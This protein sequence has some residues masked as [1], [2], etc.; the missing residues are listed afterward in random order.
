[1]KYANLESA[2][3]GAAYDDLQKMLDERLLAIP[4]REPE[5][6]GWQWIRGSFKSWSVWFGGALVALPVVL[7]DVIPILT[8]LLGPDASK[9]VVQVI[10]LVTILLRFKTKESIKEKGTS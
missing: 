7:P 10:G 8:D 5:S 4:V 9:R 6:F 2:I 3:G 1:M